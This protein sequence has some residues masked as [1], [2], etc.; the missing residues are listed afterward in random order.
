M[1]ERTF[2]MMK[3]DNLKCSFCGQRRRLI[4]GPGVFICYECVDLAYE[5]VSQETASGVP[6][7]ESEPNG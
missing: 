5:I 7:N 4:A 1:S 3:L 6:A 2:P